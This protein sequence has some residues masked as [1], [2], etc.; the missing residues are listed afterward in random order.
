M[1][2]NSIAGFLG[3][4]E[5]IK[6]QIIKE[7]MLSTEHQVTRFD[8]LPNDAE[9]TVTVRRPSELNTLTLVNSHI[10]ELYEAAA[11]IYQV[12]DLRVN[13]RD[14]TPSADDM[15]TIPF[16]RIRYLRLRANFTHIWDVQELRSQIQ[17]LA[18]FIEKFSILVDL[19]LDIIVNFGCYHEGPNLRRH[20]L[21]EFAKSFR[22]PRTF[23]SCRIS[24]AAVR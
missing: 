24:Y 13:G 23:A 15:D 14:L 20:I 5:D 6:N 9:P 2:T 16:A 19:E 18:R 11:D 22:H 3:L 4:D 8:W 10:H 17:Q 1:S 21:F 12:W 7:L